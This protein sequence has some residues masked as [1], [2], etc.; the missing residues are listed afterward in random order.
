MKDTNRQAQQMVK[1][2]RS[3]RRWQRFTAGISGLVILG[4]LASLALPAVAMEGTFFCDQQ[5][6]T[7]EESC[8]QQK[9]TCTIAEGEVHTHTDACYGPEEEILT[10]EQHVHT[11]EC[12]RTEPAVSCQPHTHGDGCYATEQVLTCQDGTHHDHTDACYQDGGVVCGYQAHG[13]GCYESQKTLTCTQQEHVCTEACAQSGETR[14]LVCQEPDHVHDASCYTRQRPLLCTQSTEQPHVHTESCYEQ[15]L[16]CTQQE[17][18]HTLA[19][20]SDPQADIELPEQW[21]RE[22]PRELTGNWPEDV[23]AVAKSQMRYT[24]SEKNFVV[25]EDGVTQH[26]YSRYGAW[27]GQPYAPWNTLFAAFC[28]HYAGVKDMPTDPD[29]AVWVRKLSGEMEG[30]EEWN[31]YRPADA[32]TAQPGELAF[33]DSDADAQA[34]AVA[35]VTGFFPGA[36]TTP[37]MLE[38]IWGTTE[39]KRKTYNLEVPE[40]EDPVILGYAAL[41]PQPEEAPQESEQPQEPEQ[42]QE[43]TQTAQGEQFDVTVTYTQEAA[44]PEGAQLQAS[45]YAKDSPVYKARYNEAAQRYEWTE[46]HTD[47]FRLFSIGFYLG[48][49]EVEPAAPVMVRISY[50]G[51]EAQE[52]Q[53]T[54]YAPLEQENEVVQEP[55][56]EEQTQ[57]PQADQPTQEQSG[58]DTPQ[59]EQPSEDTTQPEQPDADTTQPE[60]AQTYQVNVT[61]TFADGTQT[62]EFEVGRFS[63]FGVLARAEP[64]LLAATKFV[65][66][67]EAT[68]TILGNEKPTEGKERGEGY[69]VAK[70]V[71]FGKCQAN[72]GGSGFFTAEVPNPDAVTEFD[73]Y[74]KWEVE[75]ERSWGR[76]YYCLKTE[77][78]GTPYYL[79]IEAKNENGL[80]LVERKEDATRLSIQQYEAGKVRFYLQGT[81]SSQNTT[82]SINKLGG[83]PNDGRPYGTYQSGKVDRNEY[84][85]LVTDVI[86]GT[87]PSFTGLTPRG[88]VIHAFDYWLKEQGAADNQDPESVLSAGINNGHSLKFRAGPGPFSEDSINGYKRNEMKQGIVQN[89][90]VNGYPVLTQGRDVGVD[91]LQ[92]GPNES[93]QYLFDPNL[94]AVGKASYPNTYGLLQDQGGYYVYDCRENFAQLDRDTRQFTLYAEPGVN[95][96]GAGADAAGRGQFFPFNDM[97]A[98]KDFGS[99]DPQINHYFGLTLTS[100]FVQDY[101]G[102]TNSKQEAHMVFEFSGDDDVWIFIDDVLVA[103]LGGI[104]QAFQVQIDFVTGAVEISDLA[105]KPRVKTTLRKQF[106]EAGAEETVQWRGNSDTFANRT[107]HT[108]KF[109]YLERGNTDSNL[110]LK[111]NLSTYPATAITKINQQGQP[112]AGAKFKLYDT[113]NDGWT[114]TENDVVFSG[115]TNLN[116]EL[117]FT[118]ADGS[119]MSPNEVLALFGRDKQAVLVETDVPQGFRKVDEDI[120]LRYVQT[121]SNSNVHVLTCV[122]TAASGAYTTPNVLVHAPNS[123]SPVNPEKGTV[124]LTPNKGKLFAVVLKY[125]GKDELVQTQNNWR[126]IIGDYASGFSLVSPDGTL[127]GDAFIEA[128]IKAAMSYGEKHVFALSPSGSMQ[129]QLDNLPGD[130]TSYYHMVT[131]D[132]RRA[133]YTVGYYYTTADSLANATAQNT[134]RIDAEHERNSFGLS[135]GTDI[136]VPN[137]I[138]RIAVQKLD[139]AGKP[140][141]GA[142]FGLYRVYE[143]AQGDPENPGEPAKILYYSGILGGESGGIVLADATDV[144][145][146][147]D[148]TITGMWQGQQFIITPDEDAYGTPLICTTKETADPPYQDSATA[149]L[150]YLIEGQYALREIKAPVGYQ[151]NETEILVYVTPNAIYANAG[152]PDDGVIVARGPG[153]LSANLN[154]YASKGVVNNTLHWIYAQLKIS[155][156]SHSFATVNAEHYNNNG[157]YICN[158]TAKNFAAVTVLKDA[159]GKDRLT[160]FYV[161]EGT[162]GDHRFNYVMDKDS[163]LSEYNH[164]Q[165]RLETDIGWSYL[166][167]YQNAD[168]G[169]ENH[170]PGAEYES[171]NGDLS[172]LFS[173]SV[174]IKVTD[175][176]MDCTLEIEKQ[177]VNGPADENQPFGFTVKL[178]DAD[179]KDLPDTYTYTIQTKQG[180]TWAAGEEQQLASGDT[181]QLTHDQKAVITGIPKGS[182]YTVTE[183]ANAYAPEAEEKVWQ[184]DKPGTNTYTGQT[185]QDLSV[186]GQMYWHGT[187]DALDT[188]SYVKFTNTHLPTLTLKKVSSDTPQKPLSGAVFTLYRTTGEG[189]EYFDGTIW[190]PQRENTPP[191]LTSDAMGEILLQS[192]P[193]GTY[194]LE[195]NKAPDGYVRFHGTAVITVKDGIIAKVDMETQSTIQPRFEISEDGLTL[196]IPNQTGTVLPQTG[197]HGTWPMTLLGA[198]LTLTAAAFLLRKRKTA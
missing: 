68:G 81:W 87:V 145:I 55:A 18:I 105:G 109:F 146:G 93:L 152:E 85:Y 33:L 89:K 161:Y 5:E 88:T 187:A 44:L 2:S 163:V 95:P 62:V 6:H 98:V 76:T 20:Q 63:D 140:L 71:D 147:E 11:D 156:V 67:N 50:P 28:L 91:Q 154:E 169:N 51:L 65:M 58:A 42:P 159:S 15:A 181:I 178:T 179:G 22:L 9:L 99:K 104:R 135:F 127:E 142:A 172:R 182:K 111:Y 153:N 80:H 160:N 194:Y 106:V 119:A 90:L 198:L 170:T 116:G 103:D 131:E 155:D 26:F 133:D 17:H 21:E 132:N 60:P 128:A 70:K 1:S 38:T 83:S 97:N 174:Y 144:K 125:V 82:T 102:Y 139:E 126:P 12:Y 162:P 64:R 92:V 143:Q 72:P 173:R 7:H 108:L 74:P 39:V 157:R 3:R 107:Y 54:H 27:Y 25:A 183:K 41:P 138:N 73:A 151:R 14:V 113:K 189:K 165:A 164:A 186:S 56:Q 48:Q 77:K 96:T 190:V 40:A 66:Y 188:V 114:Y 196:T 176:P 166:E 45:E 118:N 43:L 148:G 75:E 197:G 185:Q 53:V 79:Q 117:V 29:A 130:I 141:P 175:Q 195:E 134:W 10:C 34:D 61:S 177:V 168:Y 112:V 36:E 49:E 35:I 191:V 31:L 120:R 47:D 150:S 78:D 184:Q 86:D 121:Q 16:T 32:G 158:N 180:D 124:D 19:C 8:Y 123:L 149:A 37:T 4:T 52:H 110:K 84:F 57:Q 100:R 59:P 24:Q 94:E 30:F 129:L 101:D 115:V 137:L 167:I 46:D 122:N 193:D 136:S 192:I 69:L 13:D 23:V 171:W